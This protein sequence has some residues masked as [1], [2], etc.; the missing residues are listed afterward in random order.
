MRHRVLSGEVDMLPSSRQLDDVREEQIQEW[1]AAAPGWVRHRLELE[2]PTRPV[3]ERMIAMARIAHGQRVVDLACGI[4]NPAFAIAEIV[5]ANGQVLGFDINPPMIEGAQAWARA[6]GIA[7]VQFRVI[8]TELDLGIAPNSCDAATCRFGLMYMA[9]P[10]GALRALYQVLK[11]GAHVAVSTWGPLERFP[12]FTVA[13]GIIGRH[14]NLPPPDPTAPGP[15]AIPEATVL[16]SY[17]SAAGFADAENV[18]FD[19]PCYVTDTPADFWSLLSETGGPLVTLLASLTETQRRAIRDDAIRT[20][21]AMFP[22]GPVALG[23]EAIIAA[24][25]KP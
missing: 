8:P 14:V 12:L 7:N 1:T 9:D 10:V 6:N 2:T 11:S 18:V 21:G 5:G 25:R 20:L 19:V 3:T 13:G 16:E 23:G 17:L 24:A 4:G 22:S 15:S